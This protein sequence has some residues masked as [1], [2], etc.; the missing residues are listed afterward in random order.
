LLDNISRL[1]RWPES[2]AGM[3]LKFKLSIIEIITTRCLEFKI[4]KTC[5]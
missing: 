2:S 5:F 1:L 3:Q 4:L